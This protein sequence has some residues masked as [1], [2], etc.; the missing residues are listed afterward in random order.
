MSRLA[1]RRRWSRQVLLGASAGLVLCGLVPNTAEAA[2]AAA[3][4]YASITSEVYPI[5]PTTNTLPTSRSFSTSGSP[6]EVTR[7]APGQMKV[8]FHGLAAGVSGSDAGGVVHVRSSSYTYNCNAGTP[9]ASAGDVIV[10]VMCWQLS[11]GSGGGWPQ[12]TPFTINYTRG[13]TESGAL[14]TARV[15][16]FQPLGQQ[17]TPV[18]QTNS[19]GGTIKVIRGATGHYTVDVTGPGAGGAPAVT[20]TGSANSRCA[21]L[22]LG[23]GLGSAIRFYVRC[24][25][26][27]TGLDKNSHFN[28]TYA[29]GTN[30]LGELNQMSAAY[31][32][33]PHVM[34]L[35][36]TLQP[37]PSGPLFNR[38]GTDTTGKITFAR[39]GVDALRIRFGHQG[40]KGLN[41]PQF[42]ITPIG[43]MAHCVPWPGMDPELIYNS[44]HW[45]VQLWVQCDVSIGD[46]PLA[47]FIQQWVRQYQFA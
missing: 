23:T 22:N 14:A 12:L 46:P 1:N 17:F 35:S 13:I 21:M 40:D 36:N 42:T 30:L 34:P 6:T 8:V 41:N 3:A 25:D 47:F 27:S 37:A 16:G 5:N 39:P 32:Y 29:A 28:F 24:V 26:A 9:L 45:D 44:G 38:I 33:I 15:D 11:D 2:N 20:G 43:S 4:A 18:T 31:A 7:T 19:A 10:T